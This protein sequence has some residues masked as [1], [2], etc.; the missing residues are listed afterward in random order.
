MRLLHL[1]TSLFALLAAI[2]AHA[3]LIAD[4]NRNGRIDER[5]EAGNALTL[6]Q[7]DAY[8]STGAFRPTGAIVW[9]NL[10][11]DEAENQDKESDLPA[12]IVDGRPVPDSIRFYHDGVRFEAT[13]EDF[14]LRAGE[15]GWE[16]TFRDYTPPASGEYRSPCPDISP[17]KI[18]RMQKLPATT[19]FYLET[20]STL[21]VQAF[22]IF[23]HIP[24][25][26]SSEPTQRAFWGS[27]S[28]GAMN[29]KTVEITKWVNEN[30]PNFVETRTGGQTDFFFGIEAMLYKGMPYGFDT[31][32][33]AQVFNG[34]VTLRLVQVD[35]AQRR[36]ILSKIRLTFLRLPAFPGA[37]GFG[38]WAAGGRGG[39]IMQVTNLSDQN[40]PGTLRYAV[41]DDHRNKIGAGPRLMPRTVIFKKSGLITLGEKL[42]IDTGHLTV[43]GQTAPFAGASPGGITMTGSTVRV[44]GESDVTGYDTLRPNDVILRFIRSR[45]SLVGSNESASIS[46][47]DAFTLQG[48]GRVIIDHCSFSWGLDG[49][50]DVT[51]DDTTDNQPEM[52]V[53]VQWCYIQQTLRDHSK[54][55]LLNGKNGARYSIHHCFLSHHDERSPR[56]SGY[57]GDLGE[58]AFFEFVS[59]VVYNW[60]RANPAGHAGDGDSEHPYLR[61]QFLNNY[62]RTGTD[63]GSST[64][65]SGL[66][67]FVNEANKPQVYFA[68]NSLNGTAWSS[69][70]RYVTFLSS[71]NKRTTPF[72]SDGVTAHAPTAAANRIK[73][74]GGCCRGPAERD[75]FDTFYSNELPPDDDEHSRIIKM[76]STLNPDALETFYPVAQNNFADSDADLLPDEWENRFGGPSEIRHWEDRD[77]DG[78][79]NLEEYLNKTDPLKAEDPYQATDGKIFGTLE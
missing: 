41:D 40:I 71:P 45:R 79:T 47:G 50:L 44:K 28:N 60:K 75:W 52:S 9:A 39:E 25:F 7:Q 53:T 38:R 43:A 10:D 14:V 21:E 74:H 30:A 72:H 46:D 54:A 48:A 57:E 13:D 58:G 29:P 55:S 3:Q 61:Y 35:A 36:T 73:R 31:N 24:D 32:K 62:Y 15:A 5:D 76:V 59:N 4:F 33:T 6:A 64:N 49:C 68:G 17:L 34:K 23:K 65:T 66:N 78:W 77:G 67:A 19:R 42:S 37:E 11:Y 8:D 12:R 56:L 70:Y 1:V 22:H 18:K 51:Q 27:W 26:T 2:S 69:A 20:T 63:T 16:R